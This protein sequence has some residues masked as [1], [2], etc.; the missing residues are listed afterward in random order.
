MSRAGKTLTLESWQIP[1][2]EPLLLFPKRVDLNNALISNPVLSFQ[3]IG[4]R[5]KS[6]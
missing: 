5:D 6:L 2:L 4:H 1:Y 3:Q